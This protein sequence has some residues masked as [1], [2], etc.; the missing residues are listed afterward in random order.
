MYLSIGND[1]AVRERSIIGIFDLDNTSTSKRTREFLEKN[2]KEGQV[3][4]CDDLP[5]SFV[6]TAEYGLDRIYLT[7]YT[8]ATLEKRAKSEK[9]PSF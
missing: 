4:P 7:P 6:L 9:Y 2:E 8:A 3:V 5:K 1:M